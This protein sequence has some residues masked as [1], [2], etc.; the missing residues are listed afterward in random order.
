[1]NKLAYDGYWANRPRDTANLAKYAG[2]RLEREFNWQVVNLSADWTDW[3]DSPVLYISGHVP[4][5]FSDE[6]LDK[7]R[8][9]VQSGGMIF[10]HADGGREEFDKF[11]RAE[12]ARWAQVIK[13]AGIP[14]Q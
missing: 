7:L 2:K 3:L 6:D 4:P 9:Y 10:T 5:K 12:I 1:M 11:I 13:D 14:K 8:A